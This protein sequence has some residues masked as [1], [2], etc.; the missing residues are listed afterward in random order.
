MR[1]TARFAAGT[2]ALGL[3]AL[4]LSGCFVGPL[5]DG[6]SPFDDP[7]NA[8]R[9]DIGEALGPIQAALDDADVFGE[10]WRAVASSAS[11]NCEGA[12]NLRVEVSIAPGDVSALQP[13]ER[14]D[15]IDHGFTRYAVPEE[16]LRAAVVAV[17]PV[18]EEYRVDVYVVPGLKETSDSADIADLSDAVAA[19]FGAT[20]R[21]VG[22]SVSSGRYSEGAVRAFTRTHSDVLQAMGLVP[23]S[24]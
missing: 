4:L 16:V 3:A 21:G 14:T 24:G 6:R 10:T 15:V 17:V 22:F 18:A 20:D 23:A 2:V 8:S 9:S 12:C 1:T 11:D 5:I 7:S 19:V 13:I